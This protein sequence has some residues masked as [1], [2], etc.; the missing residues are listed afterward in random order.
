M[1]K[2]PRDLRKF[3]KDADGEIVV[4][5]YTIPFRPEYILIDRG[6]VRAHHDLTPMS[7]G[8]VNHNIRGYRFHLSDEAIALIMAQDPNVHPSGGYKSVEIQFDASS[9]EMATLKV[10]RGVREGPPETQ[11]EP[12]QHLEEK[13]ISS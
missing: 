12:P 5:S 13:A 9:S 7:D 10:T 11:G 1:M 4:R 6:G 2:F 8:A 3:V